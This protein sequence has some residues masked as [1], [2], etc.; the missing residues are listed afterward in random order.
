[1]EPLTELL[2]LK[3][4]RYEARKHLRTLGKKVMHQEIM[5]YVNFSSSIISTYDK[6][7]G[8]TNKN[9]NAI[10]RLDKDNDAVKNYVK[11][12][13]MCLNKLEVDHRDVLL[14]KY[15]YKFDEEE[16]EKN[17]SRSLPSIKRL[18][19]DAEVDF[20]IAMKCTVAK[21]EE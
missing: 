13:V 15:L 8:N 12:L 11:M 2:D 3:K 17:M 14:A 21:K 7:G 18:V 4:T 1:M 5:D 9:L 20:A 10:S 6:N 16:M 19:M